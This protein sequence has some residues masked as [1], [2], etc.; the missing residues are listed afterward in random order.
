VA[1]M[2]AAVLQT[3]GLLG[4]IGAD[5]DTLLIWLLKWVYF[6]CCSQFG[7]QAPR[8]MP[9]CSV[10]LSALHLRRHCS[11]AHAHFSFACKTAELVISLMS[12]CISHSYEPARVV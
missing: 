3:C 6:V 9:E 10:P 7:R 11:G 12:S 2:P 5:A 8:A 1:A 4:V